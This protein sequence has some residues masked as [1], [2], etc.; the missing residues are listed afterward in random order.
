MYILTICRL[1][2]TL[3]FNGANLADIFT[4]TLDGRYSFT[5]KNWDKIG[6]NAKNLIDSFL[7]SN[8]E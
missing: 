1:S 8:P 5:G 4:R 2:G 6:L 7:K 3:P